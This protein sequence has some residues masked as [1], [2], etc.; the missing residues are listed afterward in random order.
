MFGLHLALFCGVFVLL[1]AVVVGLGPQLFVCLNAACAGTAA[2]VVAG[3]CGDDCADEA[4]SAPNGQDCGCT[5][6]PITNG[7]A[8]QL[9]LTLPASIPLSLQPQTVPPLLLPA[10]PVRL[11]VRPAALRSPPHLAALRSV[12]L[13]C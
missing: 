12:L 13:T 6:M 1:Q 7:E 3:C 4:P 8:T 10:T 2:T 5:W 9:A 11:T